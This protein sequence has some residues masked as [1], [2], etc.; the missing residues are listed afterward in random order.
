MA[1]IEVVV[2]TNVAETETIAPLRRLCLETLGDLCTIRTEVDLASPWDLTWRHKAIISDEFLGGKRGGFTHF[3]Y[4]E[5]DIRLTFT[6]LCYWLKFRNLLRPAGLLPAFVRMEYRAAVGGYTASDAFWR[7]YA[8]AQAYRPHRRHV[9]RGH[10][11][12]RI[13]RFYLLDRE[14]AR[15]VP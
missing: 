7:V 13:T 11:E 5:D 10:V 3:I 2:F 12:S 9:P 1:A 8:A 14:L 6:N 4:L 15:G